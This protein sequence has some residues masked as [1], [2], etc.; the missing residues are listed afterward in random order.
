MAVY[1]FL[2]SAIAWAILQYEQATQLAVW[3]AI[4]SATLLILGFVLL[5]NVFRFYVPQKSIWLVIIGFSFIL[6]YL[7]VISLQ[8]F[9]E[10]IYSS[11][12]SYLD[13]IKVGK[14]IRLL[15]YLIVFS[16]W[17]LLI[18]FNSF[19][20]DQLKSEERQKKIQEMANEAERYHLKQQLQPHFLFNSLN[21][22]HALV[23]K[24]PEQARE[25][26]L[27]LADFLRLT[28][29]K[30]DQNWVKVSEEVEFLRLYLGIEKLRFGHRLKVS[31][32]ESEGA[33]ENWLPQLLLQ[34][35]LENA[36]KH[37]L[38][39]ITGEVEIAI[40]FNTL[41]GFLSVS[42]SNPFDD[43]LGSNPSGEGFG[44]QAVKRR[45]FLIFG[46]NDLL[47][48]VSGENTFIVNLKIPQIYGQN[49]DN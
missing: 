31:F 46:R 23:K 13:F 42:I 11:S 16:A 1:L 14:P 3:D 34:P 10:Q 43:S 45:L 18:Y 27:Q 21:S 24:S 6:S 37:G 5:E 41:P 7:A 49:H 22:I 26:I 40:K 30:D 35:L 19:L 8:F 4:I 9:F 48:T 17:S 47:E 32:Q 33:M 29:R 36:I 28:I 12:E 25:M 38:Y 20:D 2:V 39:G 44:L 15:F